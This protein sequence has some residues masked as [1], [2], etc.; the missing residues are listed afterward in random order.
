M[1]IGCGGGKRQEEEARHFQ[2]ELVTVGRV[3]LCEL[4][5]RQTLYYI[6]DLCQLTLN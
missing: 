4:E 2:V 1:V 5:V 3:R 6:N